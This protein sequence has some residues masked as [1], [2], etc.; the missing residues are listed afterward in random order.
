MIAFLGACCLLLGSATPV[1]AQDQDM[2]QLIL[3]IQKLDQ[4]KSILTDMEKGYADLSAGY[5]V[6]KGIAQGNFNL[7]EVF[8]DGLYLVSPVVRQYVRVADIL[9]AEE[10][11][12]SEYKTAY[13][14]FAASNKFNPHELDYLLSVYNQLTKLALQN[15]TNLLN[16]MTDSKLRMSDAERLAAIDRIYRDTGDKL[17]FL[18]SFNR[19]TM[20]LQMQRTK[21][22]NENQTLKN[23]YGQ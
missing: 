7:H 16:V 4:F 17:T 21:E 2:E 15:V 6:V 23:L 10:R 20:M 18:E 3:D 22:Q 19:K 9:T 5:G 1:K 13:S 8:L 11:I 14:R 12:L